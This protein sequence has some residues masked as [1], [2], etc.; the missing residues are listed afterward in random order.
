MKRFHTIWIFFVA[1]IGFSQTFASD[2]LQCPRGSFLA[3]DTVCAADTLGSTGV[4]ASAGEGK[5]DLSSHVNPPGVD[6]CIIKDRASLTIIE[7]GYLVNSASGKSCGR[8]YF[9]W[10]EFQLCLDDDLVVGLEK[11]KAKLVAP[12]EDCDS[13]P[14][15]C[16]PAILDG[17]GCPSGFSRPDNE[18][19]CFDNTIVFNTSRDLNYGVYPSDGECNEGSAAKEGSFCAPTKTVFVCGR[20]TFPCDDGPSGQLKIV[21]GSG[22]CPEDSREGI[23]YTPVYSSDGFGF[24]MEPKILCAPAAGQHLMCVD[25]PELFITN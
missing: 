22:C 8:G 6:F 14:R 25:D 13:D 7:G 1:M 17:T 12:N 3:L 21:E 20:H 9:W 4:M 15:S 11:N 5:C 23:I 24:T 18:V 16:K 19:M 10:T 2:K